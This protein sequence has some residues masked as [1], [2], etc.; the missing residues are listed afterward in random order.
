MEKLGRR[1]DV[2]YRVS[3]R[4]GRQDF[5]LVHQWLT[6]SCG[7]P[8]ILQDPRTCSTHV[9]YSDFDVAGQEEG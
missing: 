3:G 5:G 9:I 8:I 7:Q 6:H 2:P 1:L 4:M